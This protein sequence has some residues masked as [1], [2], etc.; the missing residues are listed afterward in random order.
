MGNSLTCISPD[1]KKVRKKGFTHPPQ[2]PR[3]SVGCSSERKSLASSYLDEDLAEQA[4]AAAML[5]RH[6]QKNGSL[7]FPRSHSLVYPS[8]TSTKPFT[9]SSTSKQ[10]PSLDH[11]LKPARL[12]AKIDDVET[13]HV[14]LVH[15][16]GFGGWC[17]Y[18]VVTLLEE[19]GVKVDAIDLTASGTHSSDPNTITSLSQY[20]QPLIDF[21]HNLKQGHQVILVGH[22]IGGACI[23]YVMELFPSK[24]AKSIF[25]AA[26]MLSNGQSAFDVLSRLQVSLILLFIAS[27]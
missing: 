20:I 9:K 27:I 23:S 21:L 24:I 13:K 15:G 26:P 7:P 4:I 17:W 18:K 3:N 1:K 12:D 25:I 5:F 22:D 6:H 14:M 8:Q 2:P 19:N 11:L 16:G 10:R